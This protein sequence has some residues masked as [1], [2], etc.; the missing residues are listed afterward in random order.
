LAREV[1]VKRTYAAG[2]VEG[3]LITLGRSTVQHADL[4]DPVA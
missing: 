4:E 3:T 2:D 1:G